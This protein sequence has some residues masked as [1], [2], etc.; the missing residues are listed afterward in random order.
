MCSAAEQPVLDRLADQRDR[1]E[2]A[3][4]HLGRPEAHLP[5]GQDIA[6]EGGRHHQEED[7]EAEHPHHLA[8][9]LVGAVIEAAEDV[10]IGD[11]E[12][13]A[14]A[15]G[16]EVA[17]EPALVDVAHDMLDRGEGGVGVRR[18]V[19]GK[20]DAGDDLDGQREARE[21]PEIP[22]VIE[23]ARHRIAAA[24]RIVGEPRQRQPVV[25]PAHERMLGSIFLSPGKAHVRKLFQRQPGRKANLPPTGSGAAWA[26]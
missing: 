12:E 22:H 26:A 24:D 7:D 14:R 3:G 8:R 6:H 15:V 2:Q 17:Q 25:Q 4:D 16:V 19:H 5:P 21:H 13:E 23:V 1:A 9:R 18:I 10:E 11:D 20:D